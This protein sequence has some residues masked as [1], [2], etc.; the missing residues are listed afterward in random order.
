MFNKFASKIKSW[1]N[2]D[3]LKTHDNS[4]MQS[5]GYNPI[6]TLFPGCC[7]ENGSYDNNYANISR[8]AEA[9]AEVLPYAIDEKGKRLKHDPNVINV[10]YNPNEEMSVTDF[11]ETLMT[12][13]LVHPIVYILCWH[14]EGNDV[15]PGGPITE[16]NLAGL[17][18]MEGV[19]QAVTGNETTYYCG[20]NVWTK[21]DV[22]AL[23]LSVNPYNLFA[24]YSPSIAAK[25]WANVDDYVADYQAGFFK[26]GAIPAGEFIVTAPS[27]KEFNDIVDGLEK[28]HKG[29][30]KNNNV[31]YAHRPVNTVNGMPLVSQIEWVPFAQTTD[32]GTL[33]SI[34]DQAN[35]KIDMTFG[36][37]EEVKGHVQNSTYAS[38]EVADYIFSRRVLYPKLKKIYSKL[39]HEFNRITGGM[40][41]A[42]DFDYEP[43]VLTDTRQIQTD[44]L[45]TL[46]N[47][48]YTVESAVEAL[49][50][51][52]SFLALKE[53]PKEEPVV[54]ET[55]EITEN[56]KQDVSQNEDK[57][58][59]LSQCG[60]GHSHNR[61]DVIDEL[62]AREPD[63]EVNPEVL[64]VLMGLITSILAHATTEIE[65]NNGILDIDSLEKWVKTSGLESRTAKMFSAALLFLMMAKGE[66]AA[67]DF[68]D[69]LGIDTF[70][71]EITEGDM[72]A[73][74][75]R[76]RELTVSLADQII[77]SVKKVMTDAKTNGLTTTETIILIQNLSNSEAWRAKRTAVTEQHH[78]E[79]N[80]VMYAAITG[81]KL[82]NKVLYKTWNIHA[83]ACAECI[84]LSGERRLITEPFS[85]G[86]LVPQVHPNCRCYLTYDFAEPAKSIKLTCPECGRY[87]L[88][89]ADA[90]L[91]N[92][93]C[94]NSKCKHR[95]DIEVANGKAKFIE[96]RR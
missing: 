45:T 72:E 20:S 81:A 32:K 7:E 74:E 38:A 53:K 80:A 55:A 15:V 28:H 52:K 11:L 67:V 21:R 26:N 36:V 6:N 56:D 2:A 89:S 54:P 40:G 8:I 24:G 70:S 44:T 13:L 39:T 69:R 49:Q 87:L 16:G 68:A 51:P 37:P 18:F 41:Y 57:E 94:A 19:S 46:L 88:E 29:A 76:S 30:G 93:I 3:D 58:K 12:M 71:P 50:L 25:K 48:G 4:I 66:D 23:S 42:L 75:Q 43:P 84:P 91:K 95:Y 63:E 31:I 9:F 27:E 62:T 1:L 79:E 78:A 64:K 59:S 10:L 86:E 60:C 22:I 65:T 85:N 82:A 96:R 47:A 83:G 90:K 34:F 73:I 17:T 14:Y 5:Y 92:V 77:E 33:Q 35:K 61:K